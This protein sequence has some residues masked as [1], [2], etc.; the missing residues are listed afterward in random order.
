MDPTLDLGCWLRMKYAHR[1]IDISATFRRALHL[2]SLFN[3][4]IPFL[5]LTILS[6]RK[7]SVKEG[8]NDQFILK[9]TKTISGVS[10]FFFYRLRLL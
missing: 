8:K 3:F 2:S 6:K 5:S 7:K 9:K 10:K 1:T 4:S